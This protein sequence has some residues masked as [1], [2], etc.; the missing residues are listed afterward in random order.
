MFGPKRI[1]ITGLALFTLASAAC[2]LSQTSGELVAARV[3]Q[4]VGGS[5]LTP[6]TLSII[7]SLFPKE[8]R[9]AAFGVWGIVAGISASVGP[10]LGG[11]LVTT[12]NGRG[13]GS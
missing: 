3:V 6:Q 7:T 12:L 2:G 1:F 10:I 13:G 11:Y 4:A 5:L 9:G 8:R